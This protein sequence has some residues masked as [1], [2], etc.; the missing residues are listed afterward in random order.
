MRPQRI[1]RWLVLGGLSL[2]IAVSI[3][4]LLFFNLWNSEESKPQPAWDG[5]PRFTETTYSKRGASPN[6]TLWQRMF[7]AYYDFR[8]RHGR[9]NPAAW[10]FPATSPQNCSIH[11]LL[12]QCMEVTGT[13][14][15]IACEAAAGAVQFGHSN[16]LNGAQ[17]V[18]AFE[19]ALR[20]NHPNCFDYIAKRPRPENLLLIR[21]TPGVVKVIPPSRLADYQKAGLISAPY[22]PAT[23]TSGPSAE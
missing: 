6:S 2:A 1:R 5:K 10:S 16:V 8:M 3:W 17:W 22:V 7:M 19:A 23:G 15:L 12:N 13:R 11:G 9:K 20:T 18:A 21:E 14:Y 4:R